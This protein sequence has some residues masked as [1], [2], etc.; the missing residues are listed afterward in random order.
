M[1]RCAEADTTAA[2]LRQQAE[3]V[4]AEEARTML[5]QLVGH[6]VTQKDKGRQAAAKVRVIIVIVMLIIIVLMIVIITTTGTEKMVKIILVIVVS[7]V[8]I[9]VCFFTMRT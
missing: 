2:Q 6:V 5:K 4:G 8:R 9:I 1:Q 3:S 7:I